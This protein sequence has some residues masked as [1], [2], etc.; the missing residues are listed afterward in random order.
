[1]SIIYE[2]LKKIERGNYEQKNKSE[3]SLSKP[4]VARKPRLLYGIIGLLGFICASILFRCLEPFFRADLTGPRPSGENN[5]A[6]VKPADTS[7][8][9]MKPATIANSAA[10]I[11]PIPQLTLSGV[12][13]SENENYAL[14]NNQILKT[15]DTL[16]EWLV[17]RI[18]L[19]EVEL[20]N[21]ELT[22]TLTKP[23]Q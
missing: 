1:M 2:A 6:V 3:I 10:A 21:N 22:V 12:F 20:K 13:C 7:I 18:G 15:G 14:I 5:P 9:S 16:G 17:S 11:K 4:L 23:K 19:E 8:L